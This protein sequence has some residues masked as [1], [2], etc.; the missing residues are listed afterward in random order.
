MPTDDHAR[1]RIPTAWVEIIGAIRVPSDRSS[2]APTQYALRRLAAPQQHLSSLPR[3]PR[4]G[5][6]HPNEDQLP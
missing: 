6:L 3:S 5:L 2:M 1:A 4:P